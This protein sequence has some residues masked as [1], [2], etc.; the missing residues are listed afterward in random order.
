[1]KAA[2]YRGI[3]D[4]C[5]RFARKPWVQKTWAFLKQAGGAIALA[6]RWA[7]K[8]RSILLAIPVGVL[9]VVLAIRNLNVLPSTVGI[10]LLATGEYQWMVS[11][12]LAALV[13]LAVTAVCLLFMFLSKKV[14]YPWLISVFSLALPLIIWVTNVF[15]A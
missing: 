1:M 5:Q 8:L 12:V 15:P 13:P 2:W 9:A 10:N 11:S 3:A 7:Y 6:S 14:L 4:A